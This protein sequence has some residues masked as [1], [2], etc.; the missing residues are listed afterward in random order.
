MG[1]TGA[2]HREL[3]LNQ[4]KHA[5][6][7][8]NSN[9]SPRGLINELNKTNAGHFANLID[10]SQGVLAKNLMEMQQDVKNPNPIKNQTPRED[11][12]D[13]INPT[14]TNINGFNGLGMANP[15]DNMESYS[16][17]YRS[18]NRAPQKYHNGRIP[19]SL[20]RETSQ[21]SFG[22][23]NAPQ[24]TNFGQQ[25]STNS[26]STK[27][28]DNRLCQTH[29]QYPYS[30]KTKIRLNSNNQLAAF[31]T[32]TNQ[33]LATAKTRRATH[34]EHS[35]LEASYLGEKSDQTTYA[36]VFSSLINNQKHNN[37]A[38]SKISRN[39][40]LRDDRGSDLKNLSKTWVKSQLLESKDDVSTNMKLENDGDKNC[41]TKLSSK[42]IDS[43][44]SKILEYKETGGDYYKP[45]S[46]AP[47]TQLAG[48][49][50]KDI[51]IELDQMFIDRKKS[52]SKDSS[53]SQCNDYVLE[54]CIGQGA[55]AKVYKAVYL[56]TDARIAIKLYMKS[57][58]QDKLRQ[59][60]IKR[61]IKILSKLKHENI[62]RFIDC[63]S[64]S[65]NVYL[66]VEL[67]DGT[68]L[69][70]LLK[71]QSNRRI[72]ESSARSIIKQ[73]LQ[74]L[75]YCHNRCVAHRDIKL[76]NVI[77]AKDGS[78]KLIDFGF[79]TCIPNEKKIKM[80]CGTPSYMAPEIVQRKEYCGPPVDVW[81]VGILLFVLI[82]GRFPFRGIKF[83]F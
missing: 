39:I 40:I 79:S 9:R 6:H 7:Y 21:Q 16:N 62:V 64:T 48:F 80:F 75:K 81:A 69:Y 42:N 58:A 23:Q 54:K 5:E 11:T 22:G 25:L 18:K 19:E 73:V 38:F 24:S 27:I 49:R 12:D 71:K 59:K 74:G 70:E 1:N 8:S 33:K 72:S 65:E 44:V 56:P 78:V 20:I 2:G 30:P 57:K 46:T 13:I 31:N 45:G 55:Y 63:F 26:K 34:N 10:K 76:E 4:A 14:A 36:N 47:S 68:S 41:S 83:C 29:N 61:E 32:N 37:A 53:S 15:A 28:F 82:S 17:N 50:K 35:F 43:Q 66:V 52:G 77:I 3:F 60:S 67:V 51:N